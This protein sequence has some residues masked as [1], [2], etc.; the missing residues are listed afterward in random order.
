MFFFFN[1]YIDT[2]HQG[3]G[4]KDFYVTPT[5]LSFKNEMLSKNITVNKWNQKVYDAQIELNRSEILK[6]LKADR[7]GQFNTVKE[8]GFSE[9]DVITSSNIAAV[10]FY[11]N[12]T[13]L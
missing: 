11:T 5:Y 12:F 2:Y 6:K 1:W 9:R 13:D 8:Y 10:M 4:Y 3:S 7:S